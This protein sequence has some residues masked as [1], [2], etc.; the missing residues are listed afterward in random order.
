MWINALIFSV[1]M[2]LLVIFLGT[3]KKDNNCNCNDCKCKKDEK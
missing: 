3:P 2:I 1:T